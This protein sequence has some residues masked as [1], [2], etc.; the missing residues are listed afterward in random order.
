MR[1]V[2]RRL[3]KIGERNPMKDIMLRVAFK[4]GYALMDI[5]DQVAVR[6]TP[7]KA[8]GVG[9]AILDAASRA[10]SFCSLQRI[11]LPSC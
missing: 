3:K 6:L 2:G 5:A 8:Q 11:R 4:D 10:G 1:E 7:D 9:L